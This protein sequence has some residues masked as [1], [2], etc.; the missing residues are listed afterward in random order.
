[1]AEPRVGGRI[2]DIN[3]NK[4]DEAAVRKS[5][6]KQKHIYTHPHTELSIPVI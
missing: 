1:M 3:G 6:D 5:A 4:V 2:D